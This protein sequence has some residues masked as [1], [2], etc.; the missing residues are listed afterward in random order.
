[1]QAC[2]LWHVHVGEKRTELIDGDFTGFSQNKQF[3]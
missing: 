1:M 3:S 2:M